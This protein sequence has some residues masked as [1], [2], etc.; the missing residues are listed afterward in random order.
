[1][2]FKGAQYCN[3]NCDLCLQV[4]LLR[5]KLRHL[6]V[7]IPYYCI[8]C[9][10]ARSLPNPNTALNSPNAPKV[11]A[12]SGRRGCALVS[13]LF[14]RVCI[15]TITHARWPLLSNK[16]GHANSWECEAGPALK[17]SHH[18]DWMCQVTR[19]TTLWA[20]SFFCA[21]SPKRVYICTFMDLIYMD[22]D[23]GSWIIHRPYFTRCVVSGAI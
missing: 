5:T 10:S 16:V 12:T 6:F 11:I 4:D 17:M 23:L 14:C 20:C 9:V 22:G 13:H 21:L 1:M 8:L 15:I 3:N 19:Q 7:I 18:Q 2:Q